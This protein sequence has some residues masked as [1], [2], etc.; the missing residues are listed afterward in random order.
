M[1]TSL[2]HLLGEEVKSAQVKWQKVYFLFIQPTHSLFTLDREPG[3]T[4]VVGAGGELIKH[5][6]RCFV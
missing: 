1:Y 4:L 5:T 6:L 3:K 2:V